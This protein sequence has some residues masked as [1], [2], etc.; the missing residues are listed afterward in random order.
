M[1]DT[2]VGV[3]LIIYGK[4][5]R[6]DLPGVLT[7]VAQAGYDGIEAGA[8]ADEHQIEQYRAALEG[9]NLALV[10]GHGG[11]DTWEDP[12]LVAQCINGVKA[13]GGRYLITSGRSDW[14]AL[15]E[16]RA[17]AKTLDEVG[18]RC[19]DAG[20]VFCYH[21]HHWEFAE[22]GGT[23]GI[24]VLMGET[25]PALVKMC[26]DVYWVHVGGENPAEF[27]ARYG[28]RSPCL[29]FKDGLGGENYAEFRELGEGVVDIAATLKAALVCRP[30]WIVVEQDRTDKHP[31]ES[32]RISRGCLRK[33]GL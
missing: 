9:K 28:G 11:F 30:D 2:R 32:N 7:E 20:L 14:A 3:Q 13:L 16:Y 23:R 5:T 33:L 27:V 17:A 18:R 8:P 15:D 12:A 4:R 26:P 25:D 29:H 10:G 19:R 21:N 24:H 31:T 6:T 22:F 1:P